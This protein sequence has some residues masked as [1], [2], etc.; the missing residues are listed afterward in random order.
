MIALYIQ[1]LFKPMQTLLKR[2]AKM[3]LKMSAEV[4][5]CK[6]C[7]TL[8]TNISLE[9]NSVDQERTARSSLIWV[10]TV[11]DRSL[12]NISADQK[13]RQLVLGLAHSEL[14][15][16]LMSSTREI[17]TRFNAIR[18]PFGHSI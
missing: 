8:L 7:L 1:V 10:H 3:Q 4:A 11:C 18:L 12:S 9:A 15:T 5:R 6:K 17:F 14:N 16:L 13:S 2:Q